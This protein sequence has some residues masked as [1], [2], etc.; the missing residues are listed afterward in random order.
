MNKFWKQKLLGWVTAIGILTSLLPLTAFAE[1]GENANI[2]LTPDFDSYCA[3]LSD[4][5]QDYPAE[6]NPSLFSEDTKDFQTKRLIVK[7]TEPI[8]TRNADKVLKGY[9]NRYILQFDTVTDAVQAYNTYLTTNGVEWAEPDKIVTFDGTRSSMQSDNEVSDL[10]NGWGL[11]QIKI[12]AYTTYLLQNHGPVTSLPEIK[13]AVVDSGLDMEHPFFNGR[14]ASGEKDFYASQ[15]MTDTNG[16]GTHVSG[17]IAGGTYDLTNIK[18]LPLRVFGTE[19]DSGSIT[20]MC[21]AIDY[22][23]E[24][25]ADVINIS[26]G[27]EGFSE[28]LEESVQN[29]YKKNIPIIAAAGNDNKNANYYAPAGIEQCITV[30]WVDENLAKAS[31]SNYGSCVDIA[32]PGSSIYSTLPGSAYGNLSGTSMAAPH[33]SAA[34]AA[35]KSA[36]TSLSPDD[37]NAILTSYAE[38]VGAPGK[39]RATGA[40]VLQMA[41]IKELSPVPAPPVIQAQKSEQ[42]TFIVSISAS[43]GGTVYYTTDGSDP[44]LKQTPYTEPL[45]ITQNTPVKAIE[46]SSANP[47][48]HCNL[49]QET[50]YVDDTEFEDAFEISSSGSIIDYSGS[51]PNLVIPEKIHGVTVTSI[52]RNGIFRNASSLK[53]LTLPETLRTIEETAFY[54]NTSLRTISAPSVETI[55][56]YAFFNN[57]S[58]EEIDFPSLKSIPYAAFYQCSSL[59]NANLPNTTEIGGLAFMNC[60]ALRTALVPKAVSIA[61][62]AF[63]NCNSIEELDLSS[64]TTIGDQAFWPVANLAWVALPSTL[65]SIDSQRNFPNPNLVVYGTSGGTAQ[66]FA[67]ERKLTFQDAP[68]ILTNLPASATYGRNEAAIPLSVDVVGFHRT[69]QWYCSPD[70]SWDTA[71]EIPQAVGK[72]YIPPTEKLGSQFYAVQVTSTDNGARTLVQ[73]VFTKVSVTGQLSS[74]ASL[75]GLSYSTGQISTSVKGFNSEIN[76]YDIVLPYGTSPSAEIVLSGT[77]EDTNATLQS[78][79]ITLTDGTGTASLTVTAEDGINTKTYTVSFTVKQTEE[80]LL[81]SPVIVEHRRITVSL[82]NTS[83]DSL[84]ASA[85]IAVYQEGQLAGIYKK[86]VTLLSGNETE[87]SFV[88]DTD[89]DRCRVFAWQ[90]M[91]PLC[92]TISSTI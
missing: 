31:H 67:T 46:V 35:L 44:S 51:N 70:G 49:V 74:N 63:A 11:T 57:S 18:L 41:N 59:E 9:Q 55:G 10:I 40:G 25:K 62:G 91:L 4:L 43:S 60:S 24:Q 89:F 82:K 58:L 42:N 66:Q 68:A 84:T 87:L 71:I 61:E 33:V 56:D 2:I 22:A 20:S 16:H 76:T 29:A 72:E 13:V 8:D 32:A 73:S 27:S 69:Y 79:P 1:Y 38:D 80:N 17:I 48:L 88:A 23:V 90:G 50:F 15:P 86:D 47:D 64:V 85:Y 77:A 37:I 83:D 30:S 75:S 54:K 6:K 7:T 28:A 52:G 53:H 5:Y 81:I 12:N 34:V 45:H 92:P 19:P 14:L 26:A 78:T 3:A 21:N 65:T 39:D 36:D